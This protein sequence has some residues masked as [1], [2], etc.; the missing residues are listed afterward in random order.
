M[1]VVPS[2]GQSDAQ[3]LALPLVGCSA[4]ETPPEGAPS[5]DQGGTTSGRLCDLSL[6]ALPVGLTADL[7]GPLH[8]YTPVSS[9]EFKPC[10]LEAPLSDLRREEEQAFPSR[11]PLGSSL[12]VQWLGLRTSTAGG[13]GPN[14]AWGTKIPHGFAPVGIQNSPQWHEDSFKIIFYFIFIIY[15]FY[16]YIL[17]FIYIIYI[18]YWGIIALQW[19]VSFCF[20]TK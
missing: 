11:N 5:P 9:R 20:I 19:R 12:A 7:S 1:L 13:M 4:L 15:L 17:I 3:M 16:L 8:T 18:F 10:S 6:S 14:P 2:G